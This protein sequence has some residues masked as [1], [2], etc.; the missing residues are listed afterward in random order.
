MLLMNKIDL[1]TAF[2][3]FASRSLFL[4]FSLEYV[5]V[6]IAGLIK[7]MTRTHIWRRDRKK[8]SDQPLPSSCVHTMISLLSFSLF[9]K[10]N[11]RGTH[12]ELILRILIR[13]T[14][15]SSIRMYIYTYIYC[16]SKSY[17]YSQYV[18]LYKLEKEEDQ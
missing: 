14:C 18:L 10:D 5:C 12:T 11:R 17:Y 15:S 9:S 4:S 3:F 16:Q 2:S 13:C 6:S 8:K 7:I 1:Y